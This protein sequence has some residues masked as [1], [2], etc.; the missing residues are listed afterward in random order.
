MS[1]MMGS[2]RRAH[3]IFGVDRNL[4][5]LL[6]SPANHRTPPIKTEVHLA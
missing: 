1:S 3:S 6:V 5:F 4:V 2:R